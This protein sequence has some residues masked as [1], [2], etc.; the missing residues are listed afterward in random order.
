M[1]TAKI[2]R[3]WAIAIGIFFVGFFAGREYLR[4]EMRQI[5]GGADGSFT[6]DTDSEP[7]IVTLAEYNSIREGMTYEEV[8]SIVGDRGELT[9]EHISPGVGHYQS[10]D[11]NNSRPRFSSMSLSFELTL[12]AY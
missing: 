8:V 6:D 9:M 2:I 7:P 10:Y 1:E 12:G 4:Y 5:I 3:T 11:W